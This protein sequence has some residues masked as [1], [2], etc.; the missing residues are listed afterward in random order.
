MKKQIHYLPPEKI[1]YL[2]EK[3]IAF[4]MAPKPYFP[5]ADLGLAELESEILELRRAG[6]SLKQ[7]AKKMG[8]SIGAI[9]AAEQSAKSQI[10]FALRLRQK[11]IDNPELLN[12]FVCS[13]CKCP[14]ACP[15][16]RE[17]T[18]LDYAD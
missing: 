9:W 7:I 16:T 15:I 4:R 18:I 14:S 12:N 1:D 6:I 17:K 11:L 5:Y 13:V 3:K 2:L 10:E 8:L